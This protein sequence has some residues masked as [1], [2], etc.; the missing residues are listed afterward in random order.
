MSPVVVI[1]SAVLLVLVAPRALLVHRVSAPR[2]RRAKPAN[3][4]K[5]FAVP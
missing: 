1:A 5:H 3:V 4:V 2:Q